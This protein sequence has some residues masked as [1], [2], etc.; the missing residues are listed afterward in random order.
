MTDQPRPTENL[1]LG[2]CPEWCGHDGECAEDRA[3]I[4]QA[5]A[6]AEGAWLRAAE[7]GLDDEADMTE[8]GYRHSWADAIR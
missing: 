3:G 4:A 5:E 8:R 7:T 2:E 1:D 6:Y